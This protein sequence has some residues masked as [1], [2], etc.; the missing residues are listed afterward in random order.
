M[1]PLV[2]ILPAALLGGSLRR[3]AA[4]PAVTGHLGRPCANGSRPTFAKL[5]CLLL[6]LLVVLSSQDVSAQGDLITNRATLFLIETVQNGRVVQRGFT[7]RKGVAFQAIT[8]APDTR[9]RVWVLDPVSLQVGE[10]SF[11]SPPNGQS[12]TAPPTNLRQAPSPDRDTDGLSDLAEFILGTDPLKRDTDGDGIADGAELQQGTD[13]LSGL[14]VRTGVV[15]S[16]APAG[17]ASDIC[18]FNDLAFVAQSEGGVSVYNIFNGMNPVQVAQVDTPGVALGVACSGSLVAVADG[19]SG[20][21]IINIQDPPNARIVHQLNLGSAVL[22]VAAAG[23]FAF[24]GTTNGR[25]A[26]IDMASGQIIKDLYPGATVEDLALEGESLFAY[27]TTTP[28]LHALRVYQGLSDVMY[29]AG[30]ATSSAP[31]GVN[32]GN[33]RARLYVGGGVAYLTHHVGYNTF[34]VREPTAPAAMLSGAY[35]PIQFGWKQVVPNG[36][37]LLLAAVGPNTTFDGPHDV[38]LYR[39]NNPATPGQFLTSLVTP[40]VARAV[41]IYNGLAYVADHE[42]GLQVVNYLAYDALGIPPVVELRSASGVAGVEEGKLV[43]L[44]ALASD[45]VQVRN[46]EFYVDGVKAGTDGNFPFEFRTPAPLRSA[47]KTFLTLRARASDT[48]GNATWSEEIR[49]ELLPDSTPPI[50]LN[51]S[52]LAG[53]VVGARSIVMGFLHEPIRPSTLTAQSLRVISAGPDGLLGTADDSRVQPAGYEYRSAVNAVVAVFASPLPPGLYQGIIGPPLADLAG[54][55]MRQ[56]QAWIFR[57][58]SFAD[59]DQDGV[60]DELEVSLGLDPAKMDSDGDGTPDGREDFDND[61]L[62][63]YAEVVLNTDL[64]NPD[65]NGNGIRDGVEDQDK[66]F[67]TDAREIELGTDPRQK[68][69]D[70]DGWEDEVEISAGSNPL[71]AT[72]KPAYVVSSAPSLSVVHPSLG[73]VGTLT[74]ASAPLVSLLSPRLVEADGVIVASRPPI[75]VAASALVGVDLPTVASGT[76]P[77]IVLQ[78]FESASSN[79]PSPLL[80][81]YPPAKV[82]HQQ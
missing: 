18:A 17:L 73:E 56:D 72:S 75:A 23:P 80:I 10:T 76:W 19:P 53:E 12:L 8:L 24:A 77:G 35:Q 82:Q 13:P 69:S 55:V 42:A 48:G 59:G 79:S 16:A 30:F 22:C 1:I 4:A 20:V 29:E 26:Q 21:A 37:G 57:A 39:E 50:L 68:D 5:L 7:E 28:T 51:T 2:P 36:S 78:D 81:A 6:S 70:R 43:F 27:V 34:D 38:I 71:D 63:N 58:Y 40:G 61:G 11:T 52:P 64:R 31:E 45:D 25:L 62:L 9:Y 33:G 15:G 14:A 74:I 66:D 32:W 67:L 44:T 49:L 41:S 46:V 54:N 65:S 60:P 47:G 3:K